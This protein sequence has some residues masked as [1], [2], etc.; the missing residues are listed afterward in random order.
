[1][2]LFFLACT[3]GDG[4]VDT[5]DTSDIPVTSYQVLWHTDPDPLVAGEEGEM[6]LQV[7]DQ[8][9]R[10][11]ENLQI[12]HERMVHSVYVSADWSSFIHTHEEDY[13]AI[14]TD[15][16][17]NSTFHY[18]LTMPVSGRYFVMFDYAHEDRW[19]QTTDDVEVSGEPE[20]AAA[21]DTTINDVAEG[22]GMVVTLTWDVPAQVGIESAWSVYIQDSDGNDIT[23]LVQW[24]GADAHCAM[25][26]QATTAGSHTHAWFPDMD[27]M[28]PSMAMPHQYTGPYVPFHYVFDTGGYYKMWVQFVRADAPDSPY[29]FPFVFE[30]LG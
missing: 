21:P 2:I 22:D 29:T 17:R 9:G 14:T 7:T 30:V 5:S 24:L 3:S 26:N 12:N 10:P 6:T 15:E 4:V 25:V 13:Q 19:L 11:I 1:M 8:L 16:L 20:Q 18:P 28:A 23:D 27:Q